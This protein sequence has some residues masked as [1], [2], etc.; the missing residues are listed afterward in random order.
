MRTHKYRTIDVPVETGA[1]RAGVWE[2]VETTEGAKIPT[3][4]LIHGVTASHLAWPFIVEQL[5]DHRVIAP[6]LRGRGGSRDVGGGS[7]MRTHAKDML[8]VLDV[9]GV[10]TAAVVGHSM[11]AFVA[12]VLAATAPERVTRLILV[13]GGL[14]F[15]AQ[16]M[17][18]LEPEQAVNALLGPTVERLSMRFAGVEEYLDFWRAHPAFQ[19]SWSREVEQYFAYDLVPVGTSL[20]PATSLETTIED[21]LDLNTGST[22]TDALARVAG[23]DAVRAEGQPSVLF[24]TVPR[25]LQ[26]EEPGL[27][28]PDH[29]ERLLAQHPVLEHH[30]FEGLNHYSVVMAEH[31][32]A[33]LGVPLREAITERTAAV[34]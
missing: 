12:V 34:G 4:L 15:D 28:A 14:P 5:P 30:R 33:V 10:A 27:Y 24:C 31:G 6:D 16:A 20:R 3:A 32:A 8:A 21:M 1:L 19:S 22:L 23:P 2:P 7:S 25:G 17:P 11:G 26:D 18:D 9:C 13:D 29:V